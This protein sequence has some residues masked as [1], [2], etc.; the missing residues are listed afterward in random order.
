MFYF[1]EMQKKVLGK[2]CGWG[3]RG[4]GG[5]GKLGR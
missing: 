3:V 2:G 1:P 4:G 5:G